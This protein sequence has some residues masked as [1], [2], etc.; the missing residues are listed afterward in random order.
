MAKDTD[1]DIINADVP[2]L[3]EG[4]VLIKIHYISLDPAIRG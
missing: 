1:F 2:T 3:Q 4:Q